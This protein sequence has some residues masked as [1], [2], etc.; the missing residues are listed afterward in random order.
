MTAPT[1]HGAAPAAPQSVR[2]DIWNLPNTLTMGRIVIIPVICLLIA[3]EN[4]FAGT[5]AAILFGLAAFTDWLDGYIA[6]KRNLVSLTGKFLDPLADKLLVMAVLVTMLPLDRVPSWFV[7]ILLGRELAVNGLRALAAGEGMNMAADWGG[8]WKTAF[9]LVGLS[10]M[11]LH[12]E[13]VL[14]YGLFELTVRFNR[15]GFVL[16]LISMFFSLASGYSYFRGFLDHIARR[17]TL[18]RT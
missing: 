11:M 14:H 13:Y 2:A 9:Q 18:N 16:L 10:C 17:A 15:V 1:P 3:A 8:K 6:R 4:P 5:L 7:A 12:Y